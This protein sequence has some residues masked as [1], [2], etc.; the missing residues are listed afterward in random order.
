[1]IGRMG[2]GERSDIYSHVGQ[3]LGCLI[4]QVPPDEIQWV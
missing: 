4:W 2:V 1:M 3:Y